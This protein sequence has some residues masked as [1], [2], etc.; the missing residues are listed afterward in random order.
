MHTLV[1]IIARNVDHYTKVQT[2]IDMLTKELRALTFE[3][4]PPSPAL[5]GLMM[6][7]WM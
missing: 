3:P 7:S 1:E 6:L 5:P 4:N 2:H